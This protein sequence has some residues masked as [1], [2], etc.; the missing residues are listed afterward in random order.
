MPGEQY[1]E[2]LEASVTPSRGEVTRAKELILRRLAAEGLAVLTTDLEQVLNDADGVSRYAERS[3]R[4]RVPAPHDPSWRPPKSDPVTARIRNRRAAS[5]AMAELAAR[6]AVIP[7]KQPAGGTTDIP[8][9]DR[10]TSGSYR[11]HSNAPDLSPAYFHASATDP[12]GYT[13]DVDLFAA[14][15]HGLDLDERTLRCLE[16]ALAAFQHSLYISSASLLGA[17]S[18][19]A[20]YAAGEKLR[21]HSTSLAAA[22]DADRTAQVIERVSELFRKKGSLRTTANELQAHAAFLRDLRNYGVHPRSHADAAREPAF[23]ESAIAVLILQT[24]RYLVRLAS[25]LNTLL[26]SEASEAST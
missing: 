21:D 17:V 18:E 24:Q 20:W 11:F 10:N 5:Q 6:G 14:P 13:V 22:L 23:S 25:A 16:E 1:G 19:G 8:V 7:M 12:L 4:L 15:I 2:V 26:E 9:D 3:E